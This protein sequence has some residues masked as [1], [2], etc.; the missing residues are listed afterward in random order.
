MDSRRILRKPAEQCHLLDINFGQE[1]TP[2]FK[3]D[4]D[5]H[6]FAK[7]VDL[8]NDPEKRSIYGC[9]FR[10]DTKTDNLY[11]TAAVGYQ[12][13]YKVRRYDADGKQLAEYVMDDKDKTTGTLACLS[14]PT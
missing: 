5:N 6:K 2:H 11:L 12:N 4:I 10:V 14:S 8:T 7:V 3:Y 9:S 1:H 13:D